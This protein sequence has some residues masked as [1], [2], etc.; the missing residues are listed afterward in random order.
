M[1]K[2]LQIPI[3]KAGRG[4]TLSVDTDELKDLDEDMYIM[5]LEEGLKTVLNS[6]MSKQILAPSKLEGEA[7]EKN[8]EA[9]LA[10]A[11]KNLADLKA[12]TVKKRAS[13]K[14]SAVPRAVLAEAKRLAKEVV[15]NGIRANGMKISHVEPKDITAMANELVASD[16]SYIEQATINV[17][18]RA[19]VKP[20]V[21]IKTF[22]KESPRLI[23]K[24]ADAKETKKSQLSATQAGKPIVK[25]PPRK[26][27]T[28]QHVTH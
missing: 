28:E 15:K 23:K 1:G 21:D 6:K 20:T 19:E 24:A 4:E 18:E 25:V 26:P 13:A 2:V 3:S 10:Q 27:T 12:G 11:S 8:K 14:A 22:I 17:A 5:L 7:L 16:P 9:A